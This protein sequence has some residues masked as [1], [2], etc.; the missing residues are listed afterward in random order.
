MLIVLYGCNAAFFFYFPWFLLQCSR[1]I[2]EQCYTGK[3]LLISETSVTRRESILN[4]EHLMIEIHCIHI[5]K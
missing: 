3:I 4:S 5:Q 1:Y 2:S